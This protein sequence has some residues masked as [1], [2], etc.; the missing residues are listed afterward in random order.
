MKVLHVI[1]DLRRQAGGPARSAQG[2]VA[3]LCRA[4]VD[5]WIWALNGDEAWIEGVRRKLKCCM[6]I[7][8]QNIWRHERAAIMV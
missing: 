1:M 6:L 7:A 4:G 3:A 5:A 8:S 2:L